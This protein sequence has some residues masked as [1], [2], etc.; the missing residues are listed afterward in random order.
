MPLTRK[1]IRQ[2]AI[3]LRRK[4]GF[5]DRNE[6][7]IMKFIEHV[8]PLVDL[9]FTLDVVEDR[10]LGSILAETV[11]ELHIIRVK[12][13]V[14][15]GACKNHYWHRMTLAHEL[16]HYIL[17]TSPNICY[18]KGSNST[19]INKQFDIEKQADMFAAELLMPFNVVKNA[20]SAKK[21]AKQCNVSYKAAG[22]Q[23]K[24]VKNEIRMR[25]KRA[26]SHKKRFGKS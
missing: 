8:L 2:V 22:I 16:G 24:I 1:D 4:F 13:S 17:H 15:E 26:K 5:S 25:K 10:E 21:V 7:P 19:Y 9:D 20:P 18:A 11:P 3:E 14:Y 12:K 6:F 23:M